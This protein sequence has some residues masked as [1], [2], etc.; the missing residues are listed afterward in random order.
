[1][2][3]RLVALGGGPDIPVDGALVLVGRHPGCDIRLESCRVSRTHCCLSRDRDEILVRDLAS[4]N[5]TMING[6]RA[7]AGRL[8]AGDELSIAHLRYR[9]EVD[10]TPVLT[11]L[12]RCG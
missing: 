5:G 3:T 4:T 9:L 10:P 11:P 2:A 7:A 1:M 12:S 6:Q 8:R